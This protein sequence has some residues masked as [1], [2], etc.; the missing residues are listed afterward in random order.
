MKRIKFMS[1]YLRG[2][3]RH[4]WIMLIATIIYVAIILINPLMIQMLIDNVI[5]DAPITNGFLQL[6]ARLLG[7]VE[8]MRT[9]LLGVGIVVVVLS[10]ISGIALFIRGYSNGVIAE[11]FNQGVR[12]HVYDHLQRVAYAYHVQS[13][14][15]DL[16]QRCISDVDTISRFLSNQVKEL[17]YALFIVIVSLVIMFQINVKMTL[18]TMIVFPIVFI[19]GFAFFKRMQ[20]VFLEVDEAEALL[21]TITKESL[22]AVRVVK[23]FNRERFELEKFEAINDKYKNLVETMIHQLGVYW[24]LSDII[25]FMQVLVVLVVSI[26]E[27]NAGTLSVGNAV[28]FVSYISTVLWPIRNVGRIISDMGKLTVAIDR[29]QEIIDV[30][31]EDIETGLKPDIQGHIVFDHVSF[32][33]DEGVDILN[34]VSFEIK[35]GETV[36][37]M[38]PTGSGKSSLVHLITRLYDPT[39]G[40]LQLDGHDI[41]TLSRKHVRANV[42]LVLQEPYLFSKTIKENIALAYPTASDHEVFEAAS[43]AAVHDVIE[44]FDQGYHTAVGEKGVTLSG[45]QK[46]RLA[47]AR[48]LISN[49]PI[50]IFDDSLSALDTQTDALIRAALKA[51]AKGITMILITHRTNSAMQADKIVVLDAGRVVQSGNHQSLM[52]EPGLYQTIATMQSNTLG[53]DDHES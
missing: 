23:A 35:Q 6:I 31:I 34:D 40:T 2:N 18:I 11:T 7:G 32:H 12:N 43:I 30:S 50:I 46:Q 20:S 53:G 49:K 3:L 10:L 38:G 39:S 51:K 14:T 8:A 19:F 15:G 45:G 27:V 48:T 21:S 41:T 9:S 42:G 37:I 26:F 28:V 1:H 17:L 44:S 13:K 29:L 33:Y 5:G 25:C 52:N 24:A 22:D 4:F 47:I 16:I 36:A